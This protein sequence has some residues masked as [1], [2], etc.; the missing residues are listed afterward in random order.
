MT[1]KNNTDHWIARADQ[2]AGCTTTGHNGD[3]C[4]IRTYDA[5]VLHTQKEKN[6]VLPE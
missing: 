6:C 2:A 1:N 3:R 5:F 4:Q